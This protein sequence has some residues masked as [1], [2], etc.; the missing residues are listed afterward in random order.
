MNSPPHNVQLATAVVID[1]VLYHTGHSGTYV[2]MYYFLRDSE[3][4]W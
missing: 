3:M 1:L 2:S 4:L